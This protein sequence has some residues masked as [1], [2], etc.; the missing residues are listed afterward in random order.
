L[1]TGVLAIAQSRSGDTPLGVV[2][3]SVLRYVNG[4][5]QVPESLRRLITML[6]SYLISKEWRDV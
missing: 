4:E 6:L 2:R 3:S 1:R 5:S